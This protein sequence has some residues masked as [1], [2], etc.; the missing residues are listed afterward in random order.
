MPCG[1]AKKNL[2]LNKISLGRNKLRAW[3]EHIYTTTHKIIANKELLHSTGNYTQYLVITYKGKESDNDYVSI[4]KLNLEKKMTT[5]CS[6]LA[7]RIPSTEE[8]DRLQSMGSQRVRHNWAIFTYKLNHFVIYLK[9]T[10]CKSTILNL[11]KEI[12]LKKK[13]LLFE[14]HCRTKENIYKSYI[15]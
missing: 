6:I 7:W 15:W 11:K 10:Y 5:H 8:P 2:F 9:L 14:R 12:N 13:I 1:V 4:Y 3:D